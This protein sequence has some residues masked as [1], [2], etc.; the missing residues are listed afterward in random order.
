MG[1]LGKFTS[2]EVINLAMNNMSGTLKNTGTAI[3]KDSFM[4]VLLVMMKLHVYVSAFGN[5]KNLRE[6]HLRQIS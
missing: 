3:S 6:L 5:L 2:L 4:L 1:S